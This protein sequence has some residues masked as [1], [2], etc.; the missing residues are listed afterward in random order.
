MAKLTTTDNVISVDAVITQRGRELISKGTFN[1]TKYAF[2]DEEIDYNQTAAIIAAT[3]IYEPLANKTGMSSYLVTFPKGTKKV[4]ALSLPGHESG[5]ITLYFYDEND[6]FGASIQIAPATANGTDS[7]Y[8]FRFANPTSEEYFSIKENPKY[9]NYNGTVA[10]ISGKKEITASDAIT[11]VLQI[12]GN[13]TGAVT[14]LTL[15]LTYNSGSY[16][17]TT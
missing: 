12:T 17:P 5:S 1:I 11:G 2:G 4:A 9:P 3:P 8:N 14:Y 7:S 10:S 15:N 16:P 13:D 6:S